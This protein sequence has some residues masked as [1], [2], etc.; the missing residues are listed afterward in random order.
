MMAERA[1][2]FPPEP[3]QRRAVELRVAADIVVGVRVERL[4]RAVAPDFPWGILGVDVD[5]LGA[6]VVLLPRHVVPALEEQDPLAGRREPMAQRSA[7]RS[8]A[9]DDDVVV[10][11]HARSG[12]PRQLAGSGDWNAVRG[13]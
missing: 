8:G 2:V 3:K 10:G 13:L 4:T 1:E 6:P 5:G 7:A 11:A 12:R 9:D